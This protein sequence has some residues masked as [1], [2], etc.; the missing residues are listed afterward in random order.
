MAI[1]QLEFHKAFGGSQYKYKHHSD[2][3]Q[4]DMTFSLFLPA[5]AEGTQVPLV[6]FLSGLTCTDDNFTHKSGFQQWAQKYGV[7]VVAPD[8]SPRGDAPNDA[9]YDLGQGAGFYVNAT[10]EPWAK[11]YRMYDYITKELSALVHGLIPNWNGKESITG[12]SMGGHG[13]LVIGLRNQERF[14]AISAFSPILTPSQTPWGKKAFTAYLGEDATQWANYDATT[15]IGNLDAVP[16]TLITQG[17]ADNFYPAE[18]DEKAFLAAAAKHGDAV[19]YEQAEGYDH[20]YYFIATF[21]EA[22][23]AFHARHLAA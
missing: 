10:E 12:H 7:A 20:S 17:L 15:L 21:M 14:S 5:I 6:W 4:S 11:Q 1:E 8:T 19:T 3:L 9:G 2:T 23:L 16:H 18:L 13:A 22:H